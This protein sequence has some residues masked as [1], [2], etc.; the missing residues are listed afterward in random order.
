MPRRRDPAIRAF[1]E[2]DWVNVRDLGVKGDNATDD[3]AAIQ[4]AIDT[5]RVLYFPPASTGHRS[6]KLRADSV[7]IG[8]HPEPDPDLLPDDTPPIAASA[9]PKPDRKRQGR[10]R[11]RLRPR[12]RHRRRQSARDGAAVAR[13]RATLVDDVKFQ[14]GGGTRSRRWQPLRSLQRQAAMPI[15]RS[16]GTRNIPACG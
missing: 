12:S 3:T 6:L 2:P 10:R 4:R 15:R 14:G 16:A 9:R 11:D 13:G 1:R 8:L 7:L 5:H